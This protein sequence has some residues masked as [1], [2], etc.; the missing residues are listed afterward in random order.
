MVVC[1]FKP[2]I[3]LFKYCGVGWGLGLSENYPI[4]SFRP[5]FLLFVSQIFIDSLSVQALC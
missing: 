3:Q 1:M 2:Y 5:A 4:M